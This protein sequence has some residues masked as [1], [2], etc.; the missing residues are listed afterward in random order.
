[1]QVE[2]SDTQIGVLLELVRKDARRHGYGHMWHADNK[3]LWPNRLKALTPI[4][5]KLI[6]ARMGARHNGTT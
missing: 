4:A 1:M 6:R 3:S 2:L 5:R